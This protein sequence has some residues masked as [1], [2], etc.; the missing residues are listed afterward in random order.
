MDGTPIKIKIIA[1]KIV[2]T[3][4]KVCKLPNTLTTKKLKVKEY[5]K[6]ATK[7]TM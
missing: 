7:T 1:G 2:Q 6:S 5:I 3:N 4:S